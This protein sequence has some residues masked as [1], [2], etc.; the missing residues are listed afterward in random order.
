MKRASLHDWSRLRARKTA[1]V[2]VNYIA[3]RQ[4][5]DGVTLRVYEDFIAQAISNAVDA[6]RR[7]RKAARS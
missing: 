2:I 3:G 7:A 5:P 4:L 1:A 6:D